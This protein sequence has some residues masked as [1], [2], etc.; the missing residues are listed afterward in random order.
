MMK[1]KYDIAVFGAGPAGIAAAVE[2]GSQGKSVILIEIN[3]KIGGVMSSCPGMMLGAGYPCEKTIGGFFEEYVQRLYKMK[4]NRAERR[5]CSLANFGDE[6]V[7]DHE[8]AINELY[9]MLEEVNVEL[10]TCAVPTNLIADE[11]KIISIEVATGNQKYTIEAGIYIDCTGNG[12]I[13]HKAGVSSQ[14]GNKDGLMMGGSLTFFM[15]NVDCDEVFK[16]RED[17]YFIEYAEKGIKEGKIDKSI[18][19]IYMLKGFREGSV[20]FNTVTVTG[21]DG[22]DSVNVIK[23]TN[24]ARKRSL[25][26]AE[27][28]IDEIPGFEN[29][30][31]TNIGPLIGVRETRRMEGMHLLT[32]SEIAKASK[33]EDGIVACDNPIDEI[34][35]DE[36]DPYYTHDS[37]L[38]K[39]FYYTIPFRS[40]VPKKIKNLLFAGRNISVDSEAFASVRGMPQCM[41]MG[42][43]TAIGA[44]YAIENNVDVQSIDTEYVVR[45]LIEKK[46]NGLVGN[47]L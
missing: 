4:P 8:Y 40:L 26:L 45:E 15:E 30:Y 32:I 38:E 10:F 7:Y 33:F 43:S 9:S 47:C 21:L 11:E 28:C 44:V 42:Q 37:A 12:D 31:I 19:Q 36:N 18:P 5:I 3:S 14:V 34:F 22:R 46:V 41:V 39:G 1:K 29:S 2:A 23:T 20:F 27:F 16:D 6:V 35:R 24:I 25:E 13:A 17:P